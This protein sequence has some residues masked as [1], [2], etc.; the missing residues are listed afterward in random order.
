M[1]NGGSQLGEEWN[2][3]EQSDN[4]MGK[5][6]DRGK[7]AYRVSETTDGAGQLFLPEWGMGLCDL[8]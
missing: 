3:K 7:Q 6:M 8:C 4:K 1:D 2:D 5:D